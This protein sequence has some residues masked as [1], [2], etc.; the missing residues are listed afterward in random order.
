[1]LG[2]D[3]NEAIAW[4]GATERGNFE[5]QNIL[6]R[7]DRPEPARLPEWR[8][9]LY[10]VRA[11][12]VW[13]GLDDKRLTAWNALA[14][15]ALA[16]AGAA[17]AREDS[18]RR[19]SRGGAFVLEELREDG[20]GRLLRTWK[21]GRGR[22]NAYLED[23]AF[24]LE[25]LLS[26]YE[27]TFQPR[28]FAAARELADTMIAASPT[29]R[30]AGSSRPRTTT[31]NWGPAQGPGGPPDPFRQ[32]QRRVRPAAPRR[33]HGRAR[34]RT[35]RGVG[36]RSCMDRDTRCLRPPAPGTRL[37]LAAVRKVALAG[38]G[39]DRSSVW[40]GR[41]SAPSVL[42][43]GLRRAPARAPTAVHGR[44]AA[45]VGER[46]ACAPVTEP[47]ELERLLS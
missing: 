20:E 4:F 2:D 46:F 34:L 47:E 21:D 18:G 30:T 14:I 17:F 39:R 28:W 3:A 19:P 25:A 11:Q 29:R 36:V 41:G 27:A 22:L 1:M 33:T 40:C 37:R 38:P 12:R 5:G 9:L 32:L 7:G 10:E 8:R 24:L 16:D 23:H 45:Y 6:V 44:A 26:L 31:S 15:S 42:A 13:P 43:G 35:P